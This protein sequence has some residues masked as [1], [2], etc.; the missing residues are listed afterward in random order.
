MNFMETK[1]RKKRYDYEDLYDWDYDDSE[2]YEVSK[3]L[4][5]FLWFLY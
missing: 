1:S 5:L 4:S 3:P 2:E